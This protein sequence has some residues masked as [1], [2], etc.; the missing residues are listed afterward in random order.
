MP[1]TMTSCYKMGLSTRKHCKSYYVAHGP[2]PGTQSL[3]KPLLPVTKPGCCAGGKRDFI[4]ATCFHI[5]RLIMKPSV[6]TA[7]KSLYNLFT[8]E[9]DCVVHDVQDYKCSPAQSL[10]AAVAG[11]GMQGWSS[12]AGWGGEWSGDVVA[13]ECLALW[14]GMKTLRLGEERREER[15][16]L[17]CVTVWCTNIN[18]TK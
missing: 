10:W 17:R 6:S 12:A 11:A 18:F 4:P 5:S 8:C 9:C 2:D 1:A 7:A 15:H 16:M 13:Q 3:V 14:T